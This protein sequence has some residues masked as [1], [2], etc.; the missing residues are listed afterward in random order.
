VLAGHSLRELTRSP[1]G[2]AAF[3]ELLAAAGDGKDNLIPVAIET[4][5]GLALRATSRRVCSINPPAV[6]TLPE[7]LDRHPTQ[8]R[9][10]PRDGV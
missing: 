7:R 5:R 9:A 10:R 6:G 1:G 3:I 8:E 4:P 2:P